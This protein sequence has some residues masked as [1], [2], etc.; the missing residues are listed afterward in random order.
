MEYV[1]LKCGGDKSS[2]GETNLECPSWSPEMRTR[3]IGQE[4]EFWSHYEN[5]TCNLIL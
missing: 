2:S 4:V 5:V 3:R 1:L